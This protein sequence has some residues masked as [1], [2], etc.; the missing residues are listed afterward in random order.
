MGTV[1][2]SVGQGKMKNPKAAMSIYKVVLGNTSI[3]VIWIRN[4]ESNI[5]F[6]NKT[7]NFSLTMDMA[8]NRTTYTTKRGWNM[9]MPTHERDF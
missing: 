3:F 7:R 8:H 6:V 2:K 4:M 9:E 5:T 1:T